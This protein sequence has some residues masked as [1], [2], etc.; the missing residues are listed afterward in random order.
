MDKQTRYEFLKAMDTI[1]RAFNDEDI[2]MDWITYGIEDGCTDYSYYDAD[3][4]FQNM[5]TEFCYLM[6]IATRENGALYVD[7]ILSR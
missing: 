7:G 5:L 6:K 4:I 1:A 2:F 3:D